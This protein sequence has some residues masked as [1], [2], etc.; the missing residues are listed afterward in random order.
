M[1][2]RFISEKIRDGAVK[3]ETGWK[4]RPGAKAPN[5]T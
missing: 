4:R 2:N 3:A 1:G 5:R